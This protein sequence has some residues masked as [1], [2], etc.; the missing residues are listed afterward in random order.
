MIKKPFFGLGK[1]KLRYAGISDLDGKQIRD[2]PLPAR[3]TLLH[4]SAG[5]PQDDPIVYPGEEV[6][7]GQKLALYETGEEYLFSTATG[8]ISGIADAQGYAGQSFLSI[9]IDLKPKDRW[10]TE[11][12]KGVKDT[13]LEK[14]LPFISHL[15]GISDS[16][17]HIGRDH[18]LKTVIINGLDQDLLVATNQLMV[19][20]NADNLAQGVDFLKELTGAES[21]VFAV[22]PYLKSEAEKSGAQVRVI[23]PLYPNASPRLLVN[24]IL[25]RPV[26]PWEDFKDLGVGLISPEGVLALRSAAMEGKVPV[27]KVITVIDKDY[28]L[29]PVR[30]RIGTPVGD[31]LQS[32]NINLSQGDRLVSGGPM[33]GRGIY[34][35]DTPVL[36]DTD[37]IMVQDKSRMIAPG[38]DPC[39]NCGECVRA[40]PSRIPVNMLIRLLE[41]G[42][43]EEA[44]QE[45][46]LLSCVECGLCSYVCV[47]R[48]PIFH[49]IMLG[50]H[51]LALTGG[52]E[53]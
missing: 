6:R 47:M 23:E 17:F 24:E 27:T 32:L 45:Y 16:C 3:I 48:I 9:T 36:H 51:E 15:P 29:T 31:I 26:P 49:Y 10:D 37:A 21:V 13:S 41:N 50:K 28:G 4:R 33:Q 34:S 20:D 53:E 40:C 14:L 19:R 42:L 2:L 1:P 38:S 8:T 43:Y 25:N 18:P 22:P 30:A 5:G 7:T 46:D 35:E 52:Q 11:L 39:I 12:E 44:A